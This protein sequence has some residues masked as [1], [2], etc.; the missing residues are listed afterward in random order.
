MTEFN[1]VRVGF[2]GM[3]DLWVRDCL[4]V[5]VDPVGLVAA[6]KARFREVGGVIKEHTELKKV[7]VFPDGVRVTVAAGVCVG[8]VKRMVAQ[9]QCV[10]PPPPPH[11]TTGGYAP[12]DVTDVNRPTAVRISNEPQPRATQFISGRL[13]L[14]CMGHY[15][16]IVKQIRGDQQPDGMLVVM[17]GCYDGTPA[18]LN[19]TAD[20]LYTFDDVDPASG[21][22]WFW[23]AFPADQGRARTAYMFAYT[24]AD[25]SRPSFREMLTTYF[26]QLANYQDI[27]LDDIRFRRVLMGGFP[28]W[29][30]SP[31]QPAF[32]RVLQ[33]A[34]A[35]AAHSPLSFGGFG[36]LLRHLP[37]LTAGITDA[38]ECDRLDRDSLAW[39]QPYQPSLSCSWLYQRSMGLAPGHLEGSGSGVQ[40]PADHVN[41][42][43][44]CNFHVMRLLGDRFMRPFLQV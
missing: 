31:L 38:L 43:L 37:R 1:P 20:L 4:N 26:D 35:S 41:R 39:L 2:K 42:L 34:D 14:D 6:I 28:C 12:M 32:N 33:V 15:S 19:T 25:P 13:M 3:D 36:S 30:D 17:G 23:E 27:S 29:Q 44:V 7:S 40:L 22:Q 21:L 5:G 18:H 11:P 8:G 10:T 16:S 24:D 9:Q